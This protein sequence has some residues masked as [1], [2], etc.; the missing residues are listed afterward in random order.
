MTYLGFTEFSSRGKRS[1]TPAPA[2]FFH[3]EPAVSEKVYHVVPRDGFRAQCTT[4]LHKT[5]DKIEAS[6]GQFNLWILSLGR[7]SSWRGGNDNRFRRLRR[8]RCCQNRPL[9][10]QI[11]LW[12]SRS[13]LAWSG[14]ADRRGLFYTYG[15]DSQLPEHRRICSQEKQIVIEHSLPAACEI[16]PENA[17]DMADAFSWKMESKPLTIVGRLS[18]SSLDWRSSICR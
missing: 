15:T 1:R 6:L 7:G 2:A 8:R 4:S 11:D 5:L 18:F 14:R 10:S 16:P 17:A 12:S 3:L 13:A 9:G